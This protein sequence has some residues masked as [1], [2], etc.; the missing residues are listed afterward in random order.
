[1]IEIL[2]QTPEDVMTSGEILVALR[3]QAKALEAELLALDQAILADPPR[4]GERNSAALFA[5]AEQYCALHAAISSLG[6]W[7]FN[8]GQLGT[9]FAHGGWLSAVLA[10]RG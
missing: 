1:L 5:Y 10:R 9:F 8:R 6:I 7:L 3:S 4:L 2:D